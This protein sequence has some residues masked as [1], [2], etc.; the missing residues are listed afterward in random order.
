MT[1]KSPIFPINFIL[2]EL[3]VIFVFAEGFL[4]I[5]KNLHLTILLAILQFPYYLKFRTIFLPF[6]PNYLLF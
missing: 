2:Q 4:S 6:L 3:I 5:K 1:L